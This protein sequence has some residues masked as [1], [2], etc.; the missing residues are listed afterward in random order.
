MRD[1]GEETTLSNTV[2]ELQKLPW[3]AWHMYSKIQFK[4]FF[5]CR[6]FEE[7]HH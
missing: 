3:S 6:G 5:E 4:V 1:R 7:N 2:T